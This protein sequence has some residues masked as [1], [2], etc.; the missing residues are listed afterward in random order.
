MYP[1][2]NPSAQDILSPSRAG[3]PSHALLA[4]TSCPPPSPP[5]ATSHRPP[6]S[7]KCG[8]QFRIPENSRETRPTEPG[9]REETQVGEAPRCHGPGGRAV[10]VRPWGVL[11]PEAGASPRESRDSRAGHPAEAFAPHGHLTR[12]PAQQQ[13]GYGVCAAGRDQ[14][15]PGKGPRDVPTNSEGLAGQENHAMKA[16][17]PR[18]EGMRRIAA[19]RRARKETPKENP[20][21][22]AA[23]TAV[24]GSAR[25]SAR[26]QD[27]SHACDHLQQKRQAVKGTAR[28]PHPH[29]AALS[30]RQRAWQWL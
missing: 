27:C 7:T 30:P 12:Q 25:V 17:W 13:G 20:T 16:C 8:I 14:G 29:H 5:T 10:T 22:S 6:C 15:G 1:K 3:G 24:R 28:E 23:Q 18:R 26:G 21:C 9:L 11:P 2:G 19:G 4:L